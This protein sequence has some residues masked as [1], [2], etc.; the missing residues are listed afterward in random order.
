MGEQIFGKGVGARVARGSL[1]EFAQPSVGG[2][3]RADGDGVGDL[4]GF[5]GVEVFPDYPGVIRT[6]ETTQTPSSN[7]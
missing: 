5:W 1:D 7:E 2:L 6:G 4:G 3:L